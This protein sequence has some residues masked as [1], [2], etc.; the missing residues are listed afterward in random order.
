MG[1][2]S[3]D[4]GIIRCVGRIKWGGCDFCQQCGRISSFRRRSLLNVKMD[5]LCSLSYVSICDIYVN[6]LVLSVRSILWKNAL[7]LWMLLKTMVFERWNIVIIPSIGNWKSEQL[8]DFSTLNASV[9]DLKHMYRNINVWQRFPCITLLISRTQVH[10]CMYFWEM[11][12]KAYL[13]VVG[14]CMHNAHVRR[15]C[16]FVAYTNIK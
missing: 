6:I 10:T 13:F 1:Y 5:Y 15:F 11:S 4:L 12:V 9:A 16:E 8:P 14:M 3:H 2:N 7:H